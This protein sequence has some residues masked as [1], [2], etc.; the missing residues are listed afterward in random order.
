MNGDLK[1]V[2]NKVLEDLQNELSKL[3]FETWIRRLEPIS[4]DDDSIY[5]EVKDNMHLNKALEYKMLIQ[6]A[7]N[8]HL[9]REYEIEF[10]IKGNS[11]PIKEK[12]V[13]DTLKS[14]QVNLNPNYTFD[15]F[16]VGSSNEMAYAACLNLAQHANMPNSEN[17]LT[18]PIFLY[19][20]SGLGKTHLINAIGNYIIQNHPNLKVLYISTEDFVN[21]FINTIRNNDYSNF[22]QKFRNVDI[23]L[24]DDIQFIESKEQMQIEFFHTFETLY[25]N[26]SKI[27]IT[28]DKSPQNLKTLESRLITRFSWGLTVDIQS[29]DYETRLA[30]LRSKN[31]L[32]KLNIDD[33]ILV[34][35]AHNISNNVRELEGAYKTV[36]AYASMNKNFNLESAKKALKDKF[37]PNNIRKLSPEF[38]IEIV[39]SYYSITKEDIMSN[40]R[41]R[42]FALPR[43][44]VMFLCRQDINLTYQEIGKIFDKDHSTVMHSCSKI[45][46]EMN[47]NSKLNLEIQEIRKRISS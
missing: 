6:T 25:T 22:R 12:E 8:I 24:V 10:I 36:T 29:P 37:S 38:I 1:E 18:N 14:K 13:K 26:N 35:I 33:D 28:C 19:G 32:N 27:I 43:Q 39:S 47:E 4:M 21:E 40:K 17:I 45:E 34:Y 15:N 44:I 2:W 42:Q 7:F 23:L 3:S 41:K 5:I 9:K 30:I 31:Y 11:I 46:T 20:G 16:I